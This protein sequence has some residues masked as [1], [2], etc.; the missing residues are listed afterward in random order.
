MRLLPDTLTL[1]GDGVVLRDWRAVDA[2]ALEPV[3]GDP[4]VCQFTSVP[5]T[6]TRAAAEQWISRLPEGRAAGTTLALAVVEPDADVA[7]GNVN[8]VRFDD[9]ERSAALGYWLMPAGRGRGL[10]TRAARLL[11]D[12]GFD[13]LGL[14]RIE[15]AILPDNP[16]S[17]RVAE[18]LGAAPE[19]VRR[20]SHEADGRAWDMAIYALSRASTSS[21]RS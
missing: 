9:A 10:A 15:L 5:W 18:R 21:S 16:E 7:L 13:A 11:C 8:L 3:C 1:S 20:N 4:A 19:G 17:Q 12:W 6:Y 2:P 14:R